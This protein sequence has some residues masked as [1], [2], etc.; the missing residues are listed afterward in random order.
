[1]TRQTA[2][3]TECMVG[4]QDLSWLTQTLR[5]LPAYPAVLIF[6]VPQLHATRISP[7]CSHSGFNN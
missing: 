4:V 7:M 3:A 1:M 5:L 6:K 2:Q